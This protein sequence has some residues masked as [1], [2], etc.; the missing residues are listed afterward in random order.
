M[1][2]N[3]LPADKQSLLAAE[4]YEIFNRDL[5]R[6]VFPRILRELKEENKRVKAGDLIPFY[7]T[8]L[9]YIDGVEY[10]SDGVTPNAS[11]GAAFPNQ[12]TVHEITGIDTRRQTWLAEVLKQNGLLLDYEEK[13]INLR[14]Y[15][16]YYPSFCPNISDDGFVID[17][18][19]GEKIT[20]DVPFLMAELK[21][22]NKR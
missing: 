6:K 19:T 21:R 18:E 16:F 13:Y 11:F 1:S 17:A 3:K 7:F 8:L 14:R 4:N 22:I 5:L 20:Q 10:L 9:S 15:I 12:S 2:K